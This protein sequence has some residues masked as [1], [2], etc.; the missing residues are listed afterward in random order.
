MSGPTVGPTI[1]IAVC[2]APNGRVSLVPN[3]RTSVNTETKAW[4]S[5]MSKELLDKHKKHETQ[6]GVVIIRMLSE[7]WSTLEERRHG[8]A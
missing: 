5:G 1:E 2:V 8:G 4:R 7:D 3:D 6:G